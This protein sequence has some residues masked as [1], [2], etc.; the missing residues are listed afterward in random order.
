MNT[1]PKISVI[2]PV[3]NTEK[4]LHHCIDSILSQT[5]TDFELLLIDDGSKDSSGAI[6][7]EYAAKDNRV[8]V[9]HKE[10]GG[11]SSARNLGLDNATGEWIAFVDADD[12]L[13]P[14]YL[15]DFVQNLSNDVKLLV[16]AYGSQITSSVDFI[17]DMLLD[18]ISWCMYYKLYKKECLNL[19]NALD[20]PSEIN[21]GEDLIANII[22]AQK[23]KYIRYLENDGLILCIFLH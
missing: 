19:S 1:T 15:Y 14:S 7:D 4:Y 3:Y 8:R 10:N 16:C 2:V 13:A 12:Y 9:F 21:I 11:V 6:C 18:K 23:I 22:Y 17:N 20:V 5:F